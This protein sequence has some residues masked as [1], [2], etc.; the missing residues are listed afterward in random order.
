M[1]YKERQASKQARAE[2]DAKYYDAVWTFKEVT[3]FQGRASTESALACPERE[4][5]LKLGALDA[6]LVWALGRTSES[7]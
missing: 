1:V 3:P 4:C 7:Y 2:Q 5:L 6:S